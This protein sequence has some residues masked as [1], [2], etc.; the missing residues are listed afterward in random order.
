MGADNVS[1]SYNHRVLLYI[2][3]CKA[4][5]YIFYCSVRKYRFSNIYLIAQN[6]GRGKLWRINHFKSFGEENVGEFKLFNLLLI[7]W[8]W[9]LVE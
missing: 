1:V 5:A 9:N 7:K 8:I 2:G 4:S 3:T 6:S